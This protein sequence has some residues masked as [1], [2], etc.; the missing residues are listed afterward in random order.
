MVVAFPRQRWYSELRVFSPNIRHPEGDPMETKSVELDERKLAELILY[1]SQRYA[2]DST[3]GQVKL[4]KALF[5]TDFAAFGIFGQTITGT[6]YQHLPEG[7][8]VLRMLPV[9]KALREDG[10]LVIQEVNSYGYTL[11]KPVNLRSPNL[12]LFSGQ[13]IALV[14]EWIERLRP[15]NARQVSDYSHKTAAWE[16]TKQGEVID[17][18]LVYIAW[19]KPNVADIRRGQEIA[20]AY[21]LL[22]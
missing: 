16:F 8:A 3:Y 6:Q 19:G 15:M 18:K 17:P 2:D 20:A 21:G 13:E 12:S 11:K 1:I 14:D 4:N 7:L 10:S 9:Q 5:F 22:A